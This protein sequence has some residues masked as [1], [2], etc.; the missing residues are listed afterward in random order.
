MEPERVIAP[1]SAGSPARLALV[2]GNAGYTGGAWLPTPLDDARAVAASLVDLDFSARSELDLDAPHL[3]EAFDD[4]A[5]DAEHLR[6]GLRAGRW[7][8]VLP[9]VARLAAELDVSRDTVRSALRLLE[10]E[11]GMWSCRLIMS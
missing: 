2:I 1:A 4:L 9:G 3:R 10:S 11:K 6:D 7:G 5:R 8:E